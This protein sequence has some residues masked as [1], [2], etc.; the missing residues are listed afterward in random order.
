M[1]WFLLI[2]KSAPCSWDWTSGFSR[3]PGC[4]NLCLC[5]GRYS[6]IYSLWSRMKC[7]VVILGVSLGLVGEG[8]GNP[9]QYFCLE[10][11][12]EGELG[13]LWSMGSQ[14]QT[15][16]STQHMGLVWLCVGCFF[17]MFRVVFLF[18][19]RINMVCLALKLV[20]SWVELGSG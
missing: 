20:G 8:N 18:C 11:S 7:P 15:W 19:W 4:E 14:C 9:I 6:W 2:V 13:G 16:L 10:N 1:L 17:L 3:F 12:K 5:S